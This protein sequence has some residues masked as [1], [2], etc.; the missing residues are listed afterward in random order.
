MRSFISILCSCRKFSSRCIPTSILLPMYHTG[1]LVR[2]SCPAESSKRPL[3]LACD[4]PEPA[5]TLTLGDL[6]WGPP[7]SLPAKAK[8]RTMGQRRSVC[9]RLNP[10][11]SVL[12]MKTS[13]K[14]AADWVCWTAKAFFFSAPPRPIGLTNPHPLSLCREGDRRARGWDAGRW[15][16]KSSSSRRK[17]RRRKTP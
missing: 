11:I 1:V 4:L 14:M 8:V 15:Q 5:L 2:V 17:R 6:T 16:E 10:L 9:L 7:P 13:K 12:S 3:F